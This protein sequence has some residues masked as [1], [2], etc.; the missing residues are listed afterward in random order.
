MPVLC[1]TSASVLAAATL[2]RVHV[3]HGAQ[4]PRSEAPAPILQ[5]NLA[6]SCERRR[7]LKSVIMRWRQPRLC[8][9]ASPASGPD[10]RKLF[11]A[12]ARFRR[13]RDACEG[14]GLP[15]RISGV[16]A[17][18]FNVTLD[19]AD[20]S[21][22]ARFWAD[23]TDYAIVEE[24]ADFAA[25]K[26]LERRGVRNLLFFKVPEPKLTKN[27]MHVDLAARD[28]D[29]EIQRIVALGGALVDGAPPQW[30]E[31]N[32]TRWVVMQDPEGNEFCIG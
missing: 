26:N 23:V 5:C 21:A 29:A 11:V 8:A 16:S 3:L 1:S 12:T 20:P 31:G 14:G 24:R 32:G 27:R 15:D 18:I 10:R 2:L 6:H 22:L 7:V 4:V 25:L 30:R 28:A 13:S 17:F 19:C 9:R